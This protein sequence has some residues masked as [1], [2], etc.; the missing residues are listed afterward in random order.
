MNKVLTSRGGSACAERRRCFRRTACHNRGGGHIPSVDSWGFE[1]LSDT[2]MA[3]VMG[4]GWRSG[5]CTVA[6]KAGGYLLFGINTI[7]ANPVGQAFGLGLVI[8]A[9]AICA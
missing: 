9:G 2:D 1:Q 5:V 3:A 4:E 8:M 7:T 6:V